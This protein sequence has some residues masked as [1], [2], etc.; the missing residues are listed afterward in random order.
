MGDEGQLTPEAAKKEKEWKNTHGYNC[1]CWKCMHVKM[2]WVEALDKEQLK[3]EQ[4]M[5][6]TK[7]LTEWLER[8]LYVLKCDELSAIISMAWVHGMPYKGPSIDTKALQ[9]YL[10]DSK[11]D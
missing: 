7:E 3:N 11:N 6:K 5:L 1:P 2:Q 9:K 4:L 10:E 8:C